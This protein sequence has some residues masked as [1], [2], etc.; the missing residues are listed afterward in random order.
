MT[1]AIKGV[2]VVAP[3]GNDEHIGQMLAQE[4]HCFSDLPF[5]PYGEPY[6]FAKSGI[7]NWAQE[8]IVA[9]SNS[10]L[11]KQ[12]DRSTL[13]AMYCLD[14]LVNRDVQS[15]GAEELQ[16]VN[17][18]DYGVFISS[19]FGG[20]DFSEIEMAKSLMFGPRRVSTY[21]AISWFYAATQG[22]WTI[23]HKSKSFAKTFTGDGGGFVQSLTA[24]RAALRLKRCRSALCGAADACISPFALRMVGAAMQADSAPLSVYSL[25]AKGSG[26][27]PGEGAGFVHVDLPENSD[28]D[29]AVLARISHWG[30]IA[31]AWHAD[32]NAN[33]NANTNTNTNTNTDRGFFDTITALETNI[34][35]FSEIDLVLLDGMNVGEYAEFEMALLSTMR[36]KNP[37]IIF[38]C[39]KLQFGRCFSAAMPIDVG[40]A[41]KLLHGT[42]FA[43]SKQLFRN[44]GRATDGASIRTILIL[45]QSVY[46]YLN[47]LVLTK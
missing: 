41:V 4:A 19:Q 24:A 2:A 23:A 16:D 30:S 43:D 46:D 28:D 9:A 27:L 29:P 25:Q 10:K 7:C 22:Q 45:G 39:P 3:F 17:L 6:R 8:Q 15:A 31:T 36:E 26:Y 20:M 32:A 21:Q 44:Q 40:I 37:P 33:A 14:R 11:Q 18:T 12:V 42:P 13:F 1:L 5:P 34:G 38:C 47:Y 35:G